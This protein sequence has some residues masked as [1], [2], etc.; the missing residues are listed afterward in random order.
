MDM[1]TGITLLGIL[2]HDIIVILQDGIQH[3]QEEQSFMMRMV[4][5]LKVLIGAI[6]NIMELQI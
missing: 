3:R 5:V 1:E 2:L 6:I 4:P